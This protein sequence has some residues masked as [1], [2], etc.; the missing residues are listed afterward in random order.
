MK[1]NKQK[2]ENISAGPIATKAIA[3]KAPIKIT[4]H[5]RINL[6]IGTITLSISILLLYV[7]NNL[8]YNSYHPDIVAILTKVVPLSIFA[9]GSFYPEP[10]ERL[11]YQLSLLCSP[12][13]IFGV[14]YLVNKKRDILYKSP[15]LAFGIN[16]AGLLAFVFYSFIIF[17]EN[18]PYVHFF[19]H[20]DVVDNSV[21]TNTYFFANNILGKFNLLFGIMLYGGLAYAYFLYEK[22]KETPLKK[23]IITI[24]SYS[25][26]AL[27]VVDIVLYNV[28]HLD[29]QEWNR[30]METNA[31][32]Y[33]VTQVFAGKSLLVD[34]YSQYGL[35][36]WMLNPVFKII[37][38]ST[39]KFTLVLGILNGSAFLFL[40]LGIKKLLKND[41]L[42]IIVFLCL[43]FW[44]YWQIKLP[45]ES[46][47]RYYYQYYPIRLFFPALVFFLFVL[48][49][50]GTQKL[51][52]M[53]LPVMALTASFAA[54]WNLDTGIVAYGATFIALIFSTIDAPSLKESIKKSVVYAAWMIGTLLFVILLF[55]ITTKMRSGEWPDFKRFFE[56]QNVFY[57]SGY[58][59]LP[60]TTI[61]FWN[62]PALVYLTACVYCV[63]YLK[64]ENQ[65][66]L[67]VIAFLII[68]GFG[69][70]TYFQGRSYDTTIC[71]VMYPA[72]II[73]GVFCN[74]LLPQI[75]SHKFRFHES[76]ILFFIPFLFLADGALSMLYYTPSIHSYSMDNAFAEK[77]EA[78]KTF[79]Q[80]MDFVMN[81]THPK[82]TVII[83]SKDYESYFYALGG[84]YNPVKLAGSTELFFKSEINTLLD[85]IKTTRYP[86]FYDAVHPWQ[87]SGDT[88]IKTLAAYTTIQKEI[89]PDHSFLLLKAGKKPVAPKLVADA[90]TIYYNNLGDFSKYINPGAKLNLPENFTVE[91]IIS[92]DSSHL[93]AGNLIFTNNSKTTPTCGLLAVQNGADLTQYMFTYGNGS[94]WC[95]GVL[96]KLSCTIENHIVMKVQKNIITVYNNNNLCGTAN[97]N[98]MLKNSDGVFFINTAFAGTVHELKISKQ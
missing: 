39:Y 42:S 94:A 7:L 24:V 22:N 31:V 69:L 76:V 56:F 83:L 25:I 17:Q 21:Q 27:T 19:V 37:G 55:L 63:Y 51:R 85:V 36:P 43:I 68:L 79:K 67:P 72:I 54:F 14:F 73:A 1:Q 61:H 60:M 49:Q 41:L 3:D 47:P 16:I 98:S 26:V 12:L 84:Y 23:I 74:K 87:N 58:F 11:Q 89:G 53:L 71:I 57:G 9:Q 35:F 70:F 77:A 92:L 75:I 4:D 30:Y 66:D 88:I 78:E 95:G 59:M 32:F 64:K 5:L 38:L 34:T 52:R 50:D 45:A 62:F 44:Q 48:Y 20:N 65:K 96:C 6:A 15:S 93:A 18:L 81:N 91:A 82:D 97:T 46:T 10:V 2:T 33:A 28:F 8:I 29:V 40:Y 80:R 90:N 86:I 13:F